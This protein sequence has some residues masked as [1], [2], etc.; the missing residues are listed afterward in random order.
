MT[1]QIWRV[2]ERWSADTQDWHFFNDRKWST[3]EEA[4][5]WLYENEKDF[6]L[7]PH[8]YRVVQTPE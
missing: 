3:R 6:A 2:E 1:D 7:H 8:L 5:Q 4:A